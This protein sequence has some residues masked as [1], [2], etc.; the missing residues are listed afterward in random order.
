LD[1]YYGLDE[2]IYAIDAG[3]LIFK[4][5]ETIQE[6]LNAQV[7]PMK[8]K[9]QIMVNNSTLVLQRQSFLKKSKSMFNPCVNKQNKTLLYIRYQFLDLERVLVYDF[10][11]ET[12]TL[13]IDVTN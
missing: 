12:L 8:K 6:Y 9:L 1:A 5:P 4:Q 2:H 10:C 11:R 13:P 7:L 3:Q